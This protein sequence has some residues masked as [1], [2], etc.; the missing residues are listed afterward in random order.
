[1]ALGALVDNGATLSNLLSAEFASNF[2]AISVDAYWSMQAHTASEGTFQVG[3]CHNDLSTTEIEQ[4]STVE[5]SDPSDII[6][7]ER[8]RR[9]ARRSGR[10]LGLTATEVLAD[11]RSIRTKLKFA[12]GEG[13]QL[14]VWAINRSNGAFTT[15]T[16]VI[17]TGTLYGRWT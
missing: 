10:F 1:M 13:H 4:W 14:A 7:V 12:I 2:Y 15:G 11:G 9:P 3:F 17:V 5:L 8:S 6:A 16:L